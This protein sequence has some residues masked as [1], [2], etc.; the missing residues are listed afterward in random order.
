VFEKLHRGSRS[1]SAP[2]AGLGLAICR[3]ILQ[4][5]GGTIKAANTPRGGA[6][7]TLTLPIEGAPPELP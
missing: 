5:H 3:S 1:A 2:G 6:Q 4:A 7:L